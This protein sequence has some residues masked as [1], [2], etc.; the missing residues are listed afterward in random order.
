MTDPTQLSLTDAAHRMREGRLT[1]RDCVEAHLDAIVAQDPVLSAFITVLADEARAEA[2]SRDAARDAGR[3]CGLLH[4]APIAIKDLF[5]TAGT[6]TTCHSRIMPDRPAAADAEVVRRLRAAGAII[7]GKTALHEF[8]TGGPSF[9]LPW[10]PARNPWIPAR[11]PGGSSSGSA[12]AVSARMAA[13]AV[14]T[15]TGGSVRHPAT[16]CSLVGLKPTYGAISLRGA[17]PLAFSL[18]HAGPITRTVEDCAYLYA[19]MVG[20]D[21]CDPMSNEVPFSLSA[22]LNDAG[23]AGMRIG[24]IEEW[25]ADADPEIGQAFGAAQTS[26]AALGAELVP[27]TLPPLD[28][29]TDCGR[30]IL[31]AEG[32]A[33]HRDWLE[34]RALEY[35]RRGRLRLAAG[36]SIDA[37]TYINAQRLR[38][39]LSDELAAVMAGLDAVICVSSLSLPCAIDD[40]AEVDRTYDRQARTPFNLTGSPAVAVPAAFSSDGL[41][42]GIQL[43]GHHGTEATILRI[44]RAYEQ[45]TGLTDRRPPCLSPDNGELTC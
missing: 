6:P 25:A 17:F 22:A 3:P 24:V 41:P 10:P 27:I 42:I 26:L 7:I 21:P 4:G 9:D 15:D 39:A 5:D 33:V 11:H 44:A 8:A 37:A 38:R 28:A 19:A 14:G 43:V 45:A 16:A 40:E 23:I 29:Y 18:D 32:Y 35:S 12:V 13:G 1:A 30:L 2:A 31:Q 20:Y 36:R 34:H